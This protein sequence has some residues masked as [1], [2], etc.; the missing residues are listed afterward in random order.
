MIIK[1]SA[2]RINLVALIEMQPFGSMEV[3]MQI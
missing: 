2:S 1:K 3:Y